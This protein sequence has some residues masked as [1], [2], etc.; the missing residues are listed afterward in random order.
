MLKDLKI[1]TAKTQQD[2]EQLARLAI[3]HRLYVSGWSMRGDYKQIVEG[4]SMEE[5]NIQLA[6][7]LF[8]DLPV[9]CVLIREDCV[10]CFVRKKYRL[11]GVGSAL[12]HGLQK[13][14][15]WWT[16]DGILGSDIFW[17]KFK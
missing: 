5:E 3:K 8:N 9:G 16:G 6:L 17:S 14:N 12:M 4:T 15:G 7:A 10:Q 11:R 2:L 13:P 1:V